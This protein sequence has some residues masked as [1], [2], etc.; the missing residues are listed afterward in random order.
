M[1]GGFYS[2]AQP[3]VLAELKRR[4]T[5]GYVNSRKINGCYITIK[6]QRTAPVMQKSK[7]LDT[8]QAIKDGAGMLIRGALDVTGILGGSDS[9]LG[10]AKESEA[11]SETNNQVGTK[12]VSQGELSSLASTDLNSR[13][14]TQTGRPTPSITKLDVEMSGDYGSLKKA[15][16]E[17]KCF[18]KQSFE[19]FEELYMIPGTEL[20]ISFGRVGQSGPANNGKF[21]GV[22]Y[23]YSF[24]INS[25][26]GYDCEIKAVAK[27]SL[28]TEL[29]V[30]SKISD[31]AREFTSDFAGL[32]ESTTVANIMDVFDYDVQD[33]MDDHEDLSSDEAYSFSAYPC[34]HIAGTD[35]PNAAPEPANDNM[36]G[37]NIIFASL[38]YIVNKLI[39]VDLLKG[40]IE[41]GSVNTK[42]ISYVCNN[43]V[44]VGKSYGKIFSAN[45]MKV[46]IM[47]TPYKYHQEYGGTGGGAIG[48]FFGASK[49]WGKK[50]PKQNGNQVVMGGNKAKLG[51]ILISRDTLRS[52]TGASDA[53]GEGSKISISTFLNKI[54]EKIYNLTG[55]AYDLTVTNMTKQQAS[56]Y[57]YTGNTEGK[58]F[59][60]DRNWVPGAGVEK[61]HLNASNATFDNSTRNVAITGKVP[62]DMAA[63][64]FVG[65][66]GT[67]SGKKQG[68]VEV[69]KGVRSETVPNLAKIRNQLITSREVIHDTGYNEESIGS[70]KSNLKAYVESVVSTRDKATF[71]KDMYPLEL[72]A[73]LEGIAGI[74]FGNACVTDLTPSR[75]S[76]PK[77]GLPKIVFTVSKTKHS[78]S[79]NDWTTDVDTICRM[80]P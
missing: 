52:I 5:Q 12:I 2:A 33:K 65:G 6:S 60:V 64:A 50:F 43:Q 22:V 42:E 70:A 71:R 16:L 20:N 1:A 38:G 13:Y 59:V 17:I 44:T 56:H 53:G 68:S 80:E 10:E 25:S 41:G 55:G 77:G 26:L 24:K 30:M 32:N 63:A 14:A 27:G 18:D 54:F 75:Y 23:D 36:V 3:F 4:K 51:N 69:V 72:T 40:N 34:A 79:P 39:N 7:D 35:C 76:N 74:Q 62:K 49:I 37:G 78:I 15:I 58:M 57:G 47:G 45:P 28:V 48:R 29:N 11:M 19:E 21:N 8:G 66:T 67:V 73:T 31:D 9:W 61:I 46:L